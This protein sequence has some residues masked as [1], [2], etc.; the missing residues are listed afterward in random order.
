MKITLTVEEKVQRSY[1]L[2]LPYYCKSSTSY[3]KIIDDKLAIKVEYWDKQYYTLAVVT[4]E[5]ALRFSDK[6]CDAE[7]FN[8][9]FQQVDSYINHLT[10]IKNENI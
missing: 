10:D 8:L 5:Y 9:A 2:Q 3:Y 1:D 4:A 6:P 7:E